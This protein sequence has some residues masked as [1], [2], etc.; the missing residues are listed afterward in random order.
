MSEQE[1]I[2]RTEYEEYK[3]RKD[4]E[5]SRQNK[6]ISDLETTVSQIHAITTSVRELAVSMKN[7]C[8]EQK[9]QGEKLERLENRDGDMW[10]T[11]IKTIVTALISG[12]VGFGLAQLV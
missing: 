1:P 6:R 9:K 4:D 7:M 2:H 3:K 12:L 11:V 8:A 10:R 5:D